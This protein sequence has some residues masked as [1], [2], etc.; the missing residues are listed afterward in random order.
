MRLQERENQ[1]MR[2]ALAGKGEGAEMLLAV[3]LEV[4][5]YTKVPPECPEQ[6]RRQMSGS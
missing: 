6:P 3:T 1:L 5:C 4:V 2:A